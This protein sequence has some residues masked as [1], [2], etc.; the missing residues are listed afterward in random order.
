MLDR[1]NLILGSG[2]ALAGAGLI[3]PGRALAAGTQIALPQ[4]VSTERRNTV[5]AAPTRA[6]LVALTFDDG[7]HPRLTPQLLDLLKA[8]RVRATFFVIG[9]NVARYPDI[10]KRMVDEG[11]EIGNH[12]WRHPVLSQLGTASVLR[13]L[14]RTSEAVYRAVQR[15][16]VTMRP[17][18]GALSAS[19][20]AM[21]AREREMPTILWSVDP[22]DWR[23]P[24]AEVVASRIVGRARP[25]AII[26]S[27]DIHAPT[28]RA[29]PAAIDGLS[30][31]GY[32]FA[33][34]SMILGQRDWSKLRWRL[35]GAARVSD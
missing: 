22:E 14:D 32:R 33:T 7:P 34:V 11:H 10:V 13:E 20:R 23:R 3:A 6:R 17:P 9:R 18:Y 35:P 27:H 26:L 25:G 29:M 2:A 21:V 24:G 12:T 19:Q 16:P 31:A 4:D 30:E 28:V 5:T 1:R 8:R 15:I